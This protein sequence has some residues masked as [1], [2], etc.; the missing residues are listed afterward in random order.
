VCYNG[1]TKIAKKRNPVK[2]TGL[3]ELAEQP[4]SNRDILETQRYTNI[5]KFYDK[6]MNMRAFN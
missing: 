2:N 6:S 5:R 4:K 1:S 3:G